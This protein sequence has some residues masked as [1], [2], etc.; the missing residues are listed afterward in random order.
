MDAERIKEDIRSRSDIVEVIS[1]YN[2]QLKRS[3]SRFKGCCPFHK[4]KTPS[5]HVDPA[6]QIFHCF[7]CNAGGDVFT[8]VQQSEGADF[9]TAMQILARRAGIEYDPAAMR[10]GTPGAGQRK[11]RLLKI[12]QDIAQHYHELLLGLPPDA[13]ARAYVNRRQ[14]EGAPMKDFLIGYAP[15]SFDHARNFLKARGYTDEELLESG[16]L[17]KKE[18]SNHVY[19]RFR[20][21]VMFPIRD[22]V[23]RVVGFSGRVLRADAPGG[24]YVNSPETPI[25]KKSQI[26]FALDRARPAIVDEKLAVLCE[27]Q[28]DVIRCHAA[29]ILNAVAAQG[30]AITADH[31][32]TLRR[33]ADEIVLVLDADTAGETAAIRAADV[34][35]EAGFAIRVASLPQGED[36]DSYILKA[37]PDAFRARLAEAVPLIDFVVR[38]MGRREDLHSEAGM[39]RAVHAVGEILRKVASAVQRDAMALRAAE[40]LGISP[41]ALRNDLARMAPSARREETRSPPLSAQPAVSQAPPPEEVRILESLYLHPEFAPMIREFVPLHTLSHPDTSAVLESLLDRKPGEDI[42]WMHRIPDSFPGARGL[43]ARVQ[44][45]AEPRHSAET[46][47]EQAVHDFILVIRRRDLERRLAA[48]KAVMPHVPPPDRASL[49]NLATTLLLVTKRLSEAHLRR[50]W[51]EALPILDAYGDPWIPGQ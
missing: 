6:K 7:G 17:T 42:G 18:D 9:P 4:E 40:R 32:R 5:F 49:Q 10:G 48:V 19:D 36:P 30:T 44:M 23:G 41:E 43:A 16:V 1:S 21:R 28:I 3:G 29:G 27:G 14:L 24:K 50:K 33:L 11:E 22:A 51:E 46:G 8:F 13:P 35:H 34:F 15:E 2:V 39:M 38:V 31:A 47:P 45:E 12:H 26:L 20:D 37:G 25:F